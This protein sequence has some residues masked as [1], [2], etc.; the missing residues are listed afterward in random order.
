VIDS[1][2]SAASSRAN[3]LAWSLL[4]LRPSRQAIHLVREIG[5]NA[6]N[7]RYSAPKR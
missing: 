3:R 1:A 7:R 5:R 4:M 2:V 6:G